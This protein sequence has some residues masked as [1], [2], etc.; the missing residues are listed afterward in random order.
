MRRAGRPVHALR[1]TLFVDHPTQE[2]S[3]ALALL[4][5]GSPAMQRTL[6]ACALHHHLLAWDGV[7]PPHGDTAVAAGWGPRLCP[8][9]RLWKTPPRTTLSPGC[10]RA[11]V[12]VDVC[13]CL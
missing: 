7:T 8:V 11:C 10:V 12:C 3:G 2:A 1:D 4:S 5:R 13:L 6:W 9:R